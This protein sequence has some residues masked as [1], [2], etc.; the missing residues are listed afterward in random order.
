MRKQVGPLTAFWAILPAVSLAEG[1][2]Y[3]PPPAD[4]L[5]ALP[6]TVMIEQGLVTIPLSELIQLG[7]GSWIASIYWSDPDIRSIM[8]TRDLEYFG[9]WIAK[10][11]QLESE[12]QCMI[13]DVVDEGWSTDDA[14]PPPEHSCP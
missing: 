9:E 13:A 10:F 14:L 12:A 8:T 5:D 11:S 7:G 2:C 1:L 4:D 3:C 6:V